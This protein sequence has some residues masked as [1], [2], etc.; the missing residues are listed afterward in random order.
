MRFNPLMQVMHFRKGTQTDHRRIFIRRRAEI[1]PCRGSQ[2]AEF[3]AALALLTVAVIMPVIDLSVVPI[4]WMMAQETVKSYSRQLAFCDSFS[5]ATKLI[6]KEPS[7]ETRLN[8][9]GGIKVDDLGLKLRCAS[10]HDPST[11]IYVA[12]PGSVPKDWLPE[13][14]RGPC[15]YSLVL[16]AKI[17]L[18]P[19]FPA[20]VK[21]NPLPGITGPFPL[22]ASGSHEWE[23]LGRNPDTGNFYLNE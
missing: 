2:I 23:N 16:E 9:L 11:A 21:G 10:I 6:Q 17:L 1:R 15:T 14:A 3:A 22:I 8:S 19:A 12:N 4:R 7:L 13:G 5:E 20:T 18:Y